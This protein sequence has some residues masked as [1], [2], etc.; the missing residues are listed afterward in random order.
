MNV[1]MGLG[2]TKPAGA[3]KDRIVTIIQLYYCIIVCLYAATACV[4]MYV[5]TPTSAMTLP[6]RRGCGHV[7]ESERSVGKTDIHLW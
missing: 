4:Y 5:C 2:S 7:H 1:R 3:T 6:P